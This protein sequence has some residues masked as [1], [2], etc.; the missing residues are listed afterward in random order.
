MTNEIIFL[1]RDIRT[2]TDIPIPKMF[3]DDIQRSISGKHEYKIMTNL[4]ESQKNKSPIM[5]L[6]IAIIAS[7]TV[8]NLISMLFEIYKKK[9]EQKKKTYS[10]VIKHKDK[11][12]FLNNLSSEEINFINIDDKQNIKVVSDKPCDY[13]VVAL[14]NEFK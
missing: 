10:I 9:W 6:V 4:N 2:R 12:Y 11:E 13:E 3:I 1:F 14:K 5:D 7:G 8:N